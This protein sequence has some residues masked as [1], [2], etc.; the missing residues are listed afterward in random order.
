M[1]PETHRS[2]SLEAR[3]CH[4]NHSEEYGSKSGSGLVIQVLPF[5]GPPPRSDRAG[6]QRADL[7]PFVRRRRTLA[8][9]KTCLTE[10]SKD[11]ACQL[12]SCSLARHL[13]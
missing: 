6:L 13:W 11:M 12:V 3:P 1:P 5:L 10:F 9:K 4:K 2:G 7:L 8:G